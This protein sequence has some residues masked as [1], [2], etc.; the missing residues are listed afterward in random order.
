MHFTR[1]ILSAT[2]LC[3]LIASGQSDPEASKKRFESIRARHENGEAIS[4]EDRQWALRYM[5]QRQGSGRSAGEQQRFNEEFVRKHPPRERTG[6]VPLPDLTGGS[7][8]GE[9]GGLYPGSRNVPPDAHARAGVALAKSIVPLDGDG[10]RSPEGKIVLLSIGMSNTTREFRMFQ[11]LAAGEK[12]NPHLVIVDG[13]QGGQTARITAD[14][15]AKFWQVVQQRLEKAGVT[16]AQVQVAWIKQANARP[17]EGFPE[18]ARKLQRD[19]EGTLRNLREKFPNLKI[20]YLSS[21]IFGGYALTP[22]NP[23]PYA[24]EGGFAVKWVISDQIAGKPELN[25]DPARGTVRSPWLAWG[26][27]LWADGVNG[28]KTD[29]LTWAEDDFT[30]NDRTHPSEAGQRKVARLLLEFLQTDPT[31]RPWFTGN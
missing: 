31:A 25:Y 6:L 24:Y 1:V 10:Q 14:P 9:A 16:S 13:A 19:L 21:R 15:Q 8:Q 17:N 20:A 23:E 2:F 11:Q 29:G 27:Y 4:D 18:A 22:L 7:Y 26:P 30:V 5:Q 3:S 12:L 28:R